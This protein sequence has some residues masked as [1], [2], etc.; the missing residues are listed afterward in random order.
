MTERELIAE[1]NKGADALVVIRCDGDVMSVHRF[2]TVH[3]IIGMLTAVLDGAVRDQREMKVPRDL[4]EAAVKHRI[5][6][7]EADKE[8]K[9]D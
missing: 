3:A 1:L 2:G 6:D 7:I 8:P 4:L 9:D 5:A